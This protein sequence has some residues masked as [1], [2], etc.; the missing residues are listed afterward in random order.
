MEIVYNRV[1]QI[2]TIKETTKSAQIPY[3]RPWLKLRR[4][5]RVICTETEGR[6]AC[7]I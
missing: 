1:T 7:A 6:L 2:N 5:T 4:F 3:H